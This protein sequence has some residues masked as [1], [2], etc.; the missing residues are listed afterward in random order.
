[1]DIPR[2]PRQ[3]TARNI[4]IGAGV[5]GAVVLIGAIVGLQP[6]APSVERASV[7]IDSVRTGDVAREV[8]AQGTLVPERTHWITAQTSARVERLLAQSGERVAANEVL[9]QLSNPD[10]QIQT[11][12]AEQEVRQAQIDLINLKVDLQSQELAQEALV[13]SARTQY[14][15]AT[16]EA[17][18]VDSLLKDGL[19]SRWDASNK[20][21]Q[22]KELTT[23]LRIEEQKFALIKGASGAKIAVKS[24]QVEQLRTIAAH[25]RSRLISLDVRAPESGVLQDLSLQLGQWVPEGTT[26]AKIVQPGQLKAVLRIFESQAKDIQMGQKCSIDTRNGLIAGH[27]SRKDPSAQ[28]GTV[29]IDVA[30]DGPLPLGAVPD[31]TVEGTVQIETLHSVLYT[32]RPASGASAGEVGLFE[33]IENGKAAMRVPVVLGRSSVNSVEIVR[34]L[35]AGDKVILSDMSAYDNVKRVR[36]K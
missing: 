12:Q 11:M 3:T 29:T 36:I 15:S 32:S 22:A 17:S 18:A 33:V 2:P 34:G 30:L 5:I 16:Q 10:V 14:I 4:G 21:A 24:A 27:V 20:K 31:V 8:R 13:A 19:I 28:S 23:R 9:L 26:L 6:A 7:I 1:L 35:K 25:Q